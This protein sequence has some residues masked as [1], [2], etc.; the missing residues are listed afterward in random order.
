MGI[1]IIIG[2][3]F[4]SEGKGKIAH[5]YANKV[6]ASAVVRVG[7]TNSGHTVVDN[8]SKVNIFRILPTAAIDNSRK[9]I[10]PAGSY[11]DVELLHEEIARSKIS[12]ENVL[13]DPK[14]V[15]IT[16]QHI[17]SEITGS[18]VSSIGSTASGIGAAVSMRINRVP[19]LLFAKDIPS[20]SGFLCDTT[21]YLRN[22]LNNRREIIIEGTQGFGL[23]NIH[24]P[25]YPYATSRDTTAAGF[26]SETGLSPLDVNNVVM[27]IRAFPI[28]VGGNSGPLPAEISWDDITL[29]A[30]CNVPIREYTSV[31]KH[32]R[33][34][35][36]FDPRIVRNAIAVNKPN[37][38]V[39]NHLDYVGEQGSE[40][41][42]P[43]RRK[44]LENIE[45]SIEQRIDY[46]G[47]D[48]RCVL[49]FRAGM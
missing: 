34:V 20:L 43:K 48:N 19:D 36:N 23:S 4:G 31:T 21:E 5:W 18:L 25:Y 37:I 2:G 22:E 9:C 45:T 30:N 3:Q 32:L 29:G 26:L 14:A 6:N 1:T 35:A 12:P 47:L 41:I 8:N 33:R 15:I 24:T 39:L 42:G 38:I 49:P 11:I 7:G 40:S 27:V 46:V 28:R 16:K 10:L 17:H 13:I 44:F